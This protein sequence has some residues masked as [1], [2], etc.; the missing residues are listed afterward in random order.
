M[1]YF[2]GK[3]EFSRNIMAFMDAKLKV[4]KKSASLFQNLHS[5]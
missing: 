1:F 4:Q 3:P 5:K 2:C